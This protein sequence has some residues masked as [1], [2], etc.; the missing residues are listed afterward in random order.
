MKGLE[1]LR[2]SFVA[3]F[4]APEIAKPAQRS[5]HD[6]AGVAQ[7]AA[8]L[9]LGPTIRSEQ[10]LDATLLNL[11]NDRRRTVS[12]VSLETRGFAAWA[13]AA[14]GY[15][16]NFIE[17]RQG[18]VPIRLIGRPRLDHQRHAARIGDHMPL[19][20]FF[21]AIGGIGSGVAPPKTARTEALSMTARDS[22]IEPR[23][24][25]RRN[26]RRCNSGH[27]SARVHSCSRRQQVTPLP[28]PISW[29][30]MFQGSPL[31]RMNRIPVKQAR[32]DTGGRPPFGET[33]CRGRSG[34]ISF[35]NPRGNNADISS[36]P[37]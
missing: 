6:V 14:T 26:S 31:L 22:R 24:P 1:V 30:S 34:S 19:A 36:P 3:Q 15:G 5:L 11:L 25:K 2:G 21:G 8:M 13:S 20:A 28:Q 10:R 12:R 29:G 23:L 32:F 9:T 16:R 4:D 17:H 7:A 18:P 37:C 27:T 35:H 33:V